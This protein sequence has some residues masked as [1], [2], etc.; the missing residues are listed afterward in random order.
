MAKLYPP[1]IEGTIPAFSGTE[2]TVPFSMS[3]M[4]SLG[5]I[6]GFSLKI[7]TVQNNLFIGSLGMERVISYSLKNSMYVNFDITN[8][9]LLRGQ[10][11]KVQLA[12]VDS[13]G[14]EGYFS[15]VGT[16]KYT[17]S[18]VATIEGMD[19]TKISN[20]EKVFL[21]VFNHSEDPSEKEYSYQFKLTDSDDE[22]IYDTGVLLHNSNNDAQTESSDSFIL[23]KELKVDKVYYLEYIVTT[24]NGLVCSSPAYR[25]MERETINPDAK[26]D[27]IAELDYAN[28]YIN[29]SMVGQKV[30][31]IER[32]VTGAFLISRSCSANPGQWDEVFRF[33]LEAEL[34]TRQLWKDF[35][36]EQG[37]VYTYALQQYNDYGLY[38]NRILSNEVEA[39]FEDAFLYD[40][41]L[42]LKIRYNPKVSS[43]KRDVLESKVETLG[44][45]FPFIFRN[46]NVDYKEF[47]IGGLISYQSDEEE[48]FVNLE[49]L[50][51]D[52]INKLSR[53]F[54]RSNHFIE[55][56]IDGEIDQNPFE[57]DK[58][59]SGNVYEKLYGEESEY[60]E[61]MRELDFTETVQPWALNR[62]RQVEEYISK[63]PKTTNLE[64]YNIA[65]ERVF[66]LKV[67]EWLTNG[68]PKLFRSPTE[69]N[70]II[71]LMNTTM[72]PE[73]KLGRMLHSFNCTAYEI[74]DF[75]Y[76]N[77]GMFNLLNIELPKNEILRWATIPL[78][79][80]SNEIWIKGM[81]P[82]ANRVELL[83]D[84]KTGSI[85]EAQSIEFVD[86]LPGDKIYIRSKNDD[87]HKTVIIGTT[88]AY[89]I[90]GLQP[91]VSVQVD[92]IPKDKTGYQHFQGQFTYSYYEDYM[93][94]F[95]MISDVT[96]EDVPTRQFIGENW[97]YNKVEIEESDYEPNKYFEYC[98]NPDYDI[99]YYKKCT[100]EGYNKDKTYYVRCNS[101]IVSSLEDIKVSVTKYFD[102]LFE[103]RPVN[104]VYIKV[105]E[106]PLDLLNE[107]L[108]L[109]NLE[110]EESD[111][112]VAA[113]RYFYY[114][115]QCTEP[116]G[117]WEYLDPYAL[118]EIHI[119]D[120]DQHEFDP[121]FDRIIITA[122]K[123]Q[124]RKYYVAKFK[125]SNFLGYVLDTADSFDIRSLEDNPKYWYFK[126]STHMNEYYYVD[127][128]R[129]IF[130][131]FAGTY[132]DPV[133]R[134]LI[135]SDKYS[136]CIYYNLGIE[137]T[138]PNFDFSKY[139]G[140]PEFSS[141]DLS[142][143]EYF[144]I[145]DL[146]TMIN[147]IY[148]S[149]GTML[150]I[151]YQQKTITYNIEDSENISLEL[152]EIRDKVN[153]AKKWYD[154]AKNKDLLLC[155]EGESKT[156][157]Q[158]LKEG[159]VDEFEKAN[160]KNLEEIL[161]N[162]N[163][164][165]ERLMLDRAY[166]ATSMEVKDWF[167]ANHADDLSNSLFFKSENVT[168]K[169]IAAPPG[170]FIQQAQQYF[171]TYKEY[172]S[173]SKKYE[174]MP[175]YKLIPDEL[176]SAM[177]YQDD[178][179]G[180]WVWQQVTPAQATKNF[181]NNWMA[182]EAQLKE[183][184]DAGVIT[185]MGLRLLSAIENDTAICDTV[186]D[187]PR[188]ELN[189]NWKI[190]SPGSIPEE[191]WNKLYL[192]N[193]GT[194]SVFDIHT[195]L[196]DIESFNIKNY[197]YLID[198]EIRNTTNLLDLFE[199]YEHLVDI[200]SIVNINAWSV[201]EMSP[202]NKLSSIDSTKNIFYRG[203]PFVLNKL[204]YLY[205][206]NFNIKN[207][208]EEGKLIINLE[209]DP[210][211]PLSDYSPEELKTNYGYIKSNVD[212]LELKFLKNIYETYKEQYLEL[213]NKELE[214]YKEAH[215]NE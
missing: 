23:D 92:A 120:T 162:D 195:I 76:Q 190:L 77:L 2:L 80:D 83:F 183:E 24:I 154:Y 105:N 26:I 181:L 34:P 40:G 85:R 21:G 8:L 93:N 205:G 194:Y 170:R 110:D 193:G 203:I 191:D 187:N 79:D 14:N 45:K 74:A 130:F 88:G 53:V 46:G 19:V 51:L 98:I 146:D 178:G 4:V 206:V 11:Y 9:N 75:S 71:R 132:I 3:R 50:G 121:G 173:S 204:L 168:D 143:I 5:D 199:C 196:D 208:D 82:D 55:P 59:F 6:A 210:N 57:D 68:K 31:G 35:T 52:D 155:P 66:K 189:S 201:Q 166:E 87:N 184:R 160:V 65:A 13:D 171:C 212:A 213:L 140:D 102:L 182:I 202:T 29:I 114:D 165:P 12:F 86:M 198:S 214:E 172:N 33:K 169:I 115:E 117:R 41:N 81:N 39:N 159:A 136:T 148:L 62:K 123:W 95:D 10:F 167:I 48:L 125:G 103:K 151:G 60:I 91:I 78:N 101:N 200:W 64:D 135:S 44:S 144:E 139:D 147:D 72:S 157:L 61:E 152:R 163:K 137:N 149:C 73:E 145:N 164:V 28:G 161:K 116:I 69:G 63:H 99:H 30:D 107:D 129:D 54:S 37:K 43:F 197:I 188:Y 70:Y 175:T 133:N 22:I 179:T 141:V 186:G 20:N 158:M 211:K 209:V 7:K 156:Y 89:I 1:V 42:Q 126:P 174:D 36:V 32:P 38:S 112:M 25:M 176:L 192:K 177:Y 180:H 49:E 113:N 106:N 207:I 18:L 104:P 97:K 109:S 47:P 127:R 142:Q 16:V 96:V 128:Q 84:P 185:E 153:Q 111:K 17:G 118:Y 58:K 27:L 119:S 150:N 108:T 94:I 90:E 215:V 67:L 134:R 138:D 56:V 15:T 122:D 131:P 124:S 100:D